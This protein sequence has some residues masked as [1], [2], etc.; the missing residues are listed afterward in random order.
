M[1]QTEMPL[2]WRPI[3]KFFQGVFSGNIIAVSMAG[4]TKDSLVGYPRRAVGSYSFC[5][6]ACE[7]FSSLQGI[8]QT[9]S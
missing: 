9:G 5:G 2:F 4:L 6:D 7:V 1:A 8:F 3:I